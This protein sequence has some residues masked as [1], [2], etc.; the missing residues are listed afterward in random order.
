MDG[1]HHDQQR[2]NSAPAGMPIVKAG[3]HGRAWMQA[4]LA[5]SGATIAFRIALAESC[6]G[7][8]R[9][10]AR[11]NKPGSWWRV[12]PIPGNGAEERGRPRRLLIIVVQ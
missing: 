10:S 7:R 2:R 5:T 3:N 11:S 9:S 1:E 6:R 4:L 12:V 8:A